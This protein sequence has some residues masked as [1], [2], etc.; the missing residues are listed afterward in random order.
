MSAGPLTYRDAWA[1]GAA[2]LQAAG[3]TDARFEAEVLLRHA[4]RRT[5]ADLYAHLTETVDPQTHLEF[6]ALLARRAR[7]EPLAYIT[8]QREFYGL[9]FLVT[10]DVLIPRPESELLVESAL[11]HLRRRRVR[12]ALVVDVGTGSGAIGIAIA[13]HRRD[14]RL[15][16]ID[17]SRAALQVARRNADRLIPRRPHRWIQADLLTPVRAPI[18]CVVANLPYI[19][20]ARLPTLEPEVAVHEPRQALTPGAGGP[21]LILRLVTQLGPR[22]LPGGIAVLEIDPGMEG[23]IAEAARKLL[24]QAQIAILKDLAEMPR[25]VTIIA[26]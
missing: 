12:A 1:A 23:E 4:G 20:E 16:G 19:P 8:G 24:P 6:E 13:K 18:D 14:V 5:R 21:D 7:R 10:P 3:I 15:L 26:G 9:D 17:I 2:R 22:L 11:D 25:V